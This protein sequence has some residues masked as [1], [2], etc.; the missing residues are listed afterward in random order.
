[1]KF[2]DL[3]FCSVVFAGT[4]NAADMPMNK[5]NANTAS[6]LELAKRYGNEPNSI[7]DIKRVQYPYSIKNNQ[8]FVNLLVQ[9]SNSDAELQMKKLGCEII[10]RTKTIYS[11][12]AP[13]NAVDKL[14]A[15]SSINAIEASQM[16]KPTLDSSKKSMN[17]ESVTAAN[18]TPSNIIAGE[19]VL[20]GI[21][22]SGI[23]LT[24]PDFSNANGTRILKL[25]D[26]S[27]TNGTGPDGYDTYKWGREYTKSIIDFA[28][29][30]IDQV[31]RVG[32]GTF[33]AG[34]SGGGGK[35]ESKFRGIAYN[36]DM[37]IVKGNKNDNKPYLADNDVIA[38]CDYL[39]QEAEKLNKAIVINL[40][41]GSSIGPH[42]G[43]SLLSVALSELSKPGVVIVSTAG[44]DNYLPLHAGTQVQSATLLE[45]PIKPNN[46]CWM[47]ENE[48]NLCD[49][50]N[51]FYTLAD[52]WYS[53]DMIDSA[54]VL[55]YDTLSQSNEAPL[56]VS[57]KAFPIGIQANK[58][59]M[60]ND[61]GEPIAMI[62]YNGT[63]TNY[64]A[65]NSGNLKIEI[66]NNGDS[67]ILVNKYLWSIVIKTK[68]QG[69]IDLWGSYP[70]SKV[71][72]FK[73]V[74]DT[75]VLRADGR[76]T[77]CAPGDGDS[78]ICVT[79]HVTKN[80][81]TN[82]FDTTFTYDCTIGNISDFS[83]LGPARNGRIL[84]LISAPGEIIFSAKSKDCVADSAYTDIGGK[85]FGAGG[86]SAAAPHV[87]GAIA[88]MLQVN[89]KLKYSDIVDI[90]EH[91]AVKDEFTGTERNNTFGLGKINVQAAINYL[92]TKNGVDYVY[93]NDV[94]VYPNPAVNT[95]SFELN[96]D[97]D[98][99]H[100]SLA[101]YN[102][103]GE[104]VSDNLRF[105]VSGSKLNLN[106]STL[107]S[108]IYNI[109]CVSGK[110]IAKFRFVVK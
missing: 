92:T 81:W 82:I 51:S 4:L 49:S 17:A 97:F 30:I 26:M 52:F 27:D 103:V 45:F 11:I 83:S 22:D 85:Y 44:N 14:S 96:S 7:M 48:T 39:M 16:Y 31:D 10:T 64:A 87:T 13:A 100:L 40:S 55:A 63:V 21:I 93:A 70:I 56:L 28:D 91:T 59:M 69:Q 75:E 76:M 105:E 29:V 9:V 53:K 101:V 35:V 73:S 80:S 19:G 67:N 43:K 36:S 72:K 86:T 23:D 15:L 2:R 46:I 77:I 58:E 88:L 38:G 78:V 50:P 20:L 74:W 5:M 68:N 57:Y 66:H 62:E 108:G 109:E 6:K 102:S 24:H 41:I 98:A 84:P 34:V 104:K 1:M 95:V 25:W 42:D 32:H 37:I 79:S 18:I 61:N 106:I 71:R 90:L 89:P 8:L 47:V 110:S 107:A 54:Y 65:N 99:N 60:L 12:K 94:K 3:L 33:V